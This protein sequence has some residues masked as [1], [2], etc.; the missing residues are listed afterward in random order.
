MNMKINCMVRRWIIK[1]PSSADVKRQLAIIEKASNIDQLATC[2]CMPIIKKKIN[3]F[4][5]IR[6][7]ECLFFH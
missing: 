1:S 6:L 3:G 5:I 7:V 2:A 4:H